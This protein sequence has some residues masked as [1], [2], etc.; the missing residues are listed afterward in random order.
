[1]SLRLV[2]YPHLLLTSIMF[3][4]DSLLVS[5]ITEEEEDEEEEER[6]DKASVAARCN[7]S[8]ITRGGNNKLV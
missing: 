1:M 2:C 3:T 4:N 8:G 5:D 7:I 6:Q